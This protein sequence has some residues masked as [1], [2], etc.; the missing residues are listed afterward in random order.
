M[1]VQPHRAHC[2]TL[3]FEFEITMNI[4]IYIHIYTCLFI[5]YRDFLH[6]KALSGK[7]QNREISNRKLCTRDAV[8]TVNRR[9]ARGHA[10]GHARGTE[11]RF[12]I[13]K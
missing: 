13:G 9:D 12:R 10:I 4:Y 7:I 3:V 1:L 6:G 5:M 11:A 2:L 8:N